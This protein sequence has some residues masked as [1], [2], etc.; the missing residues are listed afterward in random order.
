[1]AIKLTG[2]N[3]DIE[4]KDKQTGSKINVQFLHYPT[5]IKL[6]KQVPDLKLQY[7]AHQ[8]TKAHNNM[9]LNYTIT[10]VHRDIFVLNSHLNY[11]N[12]EYGIGNPSSPRPVAAAPP[13]DF[14]YTTVQKLL[15]IDTGMVV[16]RAC[17]NINKWGYARCN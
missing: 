8:K 10:I 3:G 15:N 17:L 14:P 2:Y 11:R 4:L 16:L 9:D 7:I 12:T 1:V 5:V 6:I 13:S